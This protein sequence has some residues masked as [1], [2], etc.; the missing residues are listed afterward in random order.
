MKIDGRP[1]KSG[2]IVVGSG[3]TGEIDLPWGLFTLVFNPSESTQNINLT[4]NLGENKIIFN[5]TDNVLGLA[6][7]LNI[8]LSNGQAASLNLVVYTIGEGVVA[9]R[10]VHYTAG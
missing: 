1:A 3:Q 4:S 9:T 6:T 10:I 7:T 8:P 2:T 5:G